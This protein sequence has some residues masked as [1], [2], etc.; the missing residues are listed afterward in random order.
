MAPDLSALATGWPHYSPGQPT[1]LLCAGSPTRHT[2][3]SWKGQPDLAMGTASTLTEQWLSL[4][5]RPRYS[6]RP[7]P[8]AGRALKGE[9]VY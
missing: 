6:T 4:P 3:H 1:S 9:C 5:T 2:V 7:H 8:V